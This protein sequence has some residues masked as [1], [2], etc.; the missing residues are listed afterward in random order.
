MTTQKFIITNKFRPSRKSKSA[1]IH[2]TRPKKRFVYLY[3]VP[4]RKDFN[5]PTNTANPIFDPTSMT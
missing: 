4:L 5:L 3:K 1:K 2:K